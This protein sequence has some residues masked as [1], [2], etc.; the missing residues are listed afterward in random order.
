MAGQI[1]V[2]D[3]AAEPEVEPIEIEADRFVRQAGE[4]GVVGAHAEEG[5][6]AATRI[7]ELFEERH[8]H[9]PLGD[10]QHGVAAVGG[11]FEPAHQ[12][13]SEFGKATKVSE[14]FEVG[15]QVPRLVVGVAH[16]QQTAGLTT[17]GAERSTERTQVVVPADVPQ[18]P[19]PALDLGE[20][21]VPITTDLASTVRPDGLNR[22]NDAITP[23]PCVGQRDARIG[24]PALTE[25]RKASAVLG[26]VV[27]LLV[28]WIVGGMGLGLIFGTVGMVIGIPFGIA[29]GLGIGVGTTIGILWMRHRRAERELSTPPP[30][31]YSPDG[32]WYWTGSEWI[33]AP[34]GPPPGLEAGS[35][36]RA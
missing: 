10:H 24:G 8:G 20:V 33:A 21:H 31:Q 28:G 29:A 9:L 34:N 25:E 27:D 5:R 12:R 19:S 30:P 11:D 16:D 6:S 13:R 36:R 2:C 22:R 26:L 17:R 4:L 23:Y 15:R 14:H 7:I 3:E 32:Y 35:S 18:A 1:K